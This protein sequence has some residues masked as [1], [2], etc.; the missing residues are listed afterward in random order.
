MGLLGLACKLEYPSMLVSV[1]NTGTGSWARTRLGQLT[2]CATED[3]PRDWE[4]LGEQGSRELTR[5][6]QYAGCLARARPKARDNAVRRGSRDS[7]AW[8]ALGLGLE[9]QDDWGF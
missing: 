9:V 6:D 2:D 3:R 7:P 8:A 1:R 5:L 4:C